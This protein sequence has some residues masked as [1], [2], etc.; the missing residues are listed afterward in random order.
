MHLDIDVRVNVRPP[1]R[2]LDELCLAVG[3]SEFGSDYPSALDGY[4][5]TT[6]AWT[7]A[8]R[9]V[10]WT[11]VVSDNVRHAFLLDVMVHPEFQKRG[12]GRQVVLRAIDEMRAKGVTAFHVDC[13]TDRA[14]FYEKCG[15]M[16]CAGGWMDTAKSTR[17][18]LSTPGRQRDQIDPKQNDG[19]RS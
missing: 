4:A 2:E 5:V 16:M 7:P 17:E 18:S 15:F 8:G 11:S 9:L 3:W 6:S 19:D 13:A 14:G 1:R 12:I 10:A